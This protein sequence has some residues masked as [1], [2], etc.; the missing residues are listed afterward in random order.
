MLVSMGKVDKTTVK[1]LARQF[2]YMDVDGSGCLDADDL[3]AF[4][5]VKLELA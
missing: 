4:G 5:D 3:K 2:K 1:I